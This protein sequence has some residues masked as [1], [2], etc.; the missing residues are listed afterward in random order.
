MRHPKILTSITILLLVILT[1]TMLLVTRLTNATTATNTVQ[2]AWQLARLS[3]SYSFRS[4][5]EQTTPIEPRMSSVGQHSTVNEYVISGTV[6]E[7][8][9]Q[10]LFVIENA[11]NSAPPLEIRR[12]HLKTYTRQGE[13]EWRELTNVQNLNMTDTLAYLAGVEQ[14]TATQSGQTYDFA[15]NGNTFADAFRKSLQINASRGIKVNQEWSTIIDGEQL[16]GTNGSGSIEI[17]SDGLPRQMNL[18]LMIPQGEEK[19]AIQARIV[20]T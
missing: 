3:G 10:M 1:T 5:V 2:T 8:N 18:L 6:D 20:T 12:D 13:G 17:D 15:F 11:D 14:I 4:E 16:R 7:S 9:Q 19:E